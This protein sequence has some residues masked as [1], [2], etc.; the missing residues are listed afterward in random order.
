VRVEENEV[1]A[2]DADTPCALGPV[3]GL[4]AVARDQP[5]R[6]HSFPVANFDRQI[7]TARAEDVTAFVQTT[8]VAAALGARLDQAGRDCGFVA[9]SPCARQFG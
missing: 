5:V 8:R 1:M 9:G 7:K 6:G 3:H 2:V 4:R